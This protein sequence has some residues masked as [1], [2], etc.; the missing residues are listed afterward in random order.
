MS[1]LTGH[2]AACRSS[3]DGPVW[4]VRTLSYFVKFGM[5]IVQQLN[6]AIRTE[7]D[8]FL[9]IPP[10]GLAVVLAFLSIPKLRYDAVV[11]PHTRARAQRR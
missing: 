11:A 2:A 5:D 6:G 3:G 1:G 4:A 7:L 8:S 10:A 9:Y